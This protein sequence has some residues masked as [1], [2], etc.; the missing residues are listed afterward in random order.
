MGPSSI[1]SYLTKASFS[2]YGYTSQ[3]RRIRPFIFRIGLCFSL[4]MGTLLMGAGWRM[5][6]SLFPAKE[7]RKTQLTLGNVYTEMA[8][9]S[10]AWTIRQFFL[11]P[12]AKADP[13]VPYTILR[14]NTDGEV[15]DEVE[16]N[17]LPPAVCQVPS[18]S[19]SSTGIRLNRLED[20][21]GK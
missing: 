15:T 5:A 3:E 9:L 17:E 13:Q 10:P 20:R 21:S 12:S 11:S 2:K 4:S 16:S 18:P 7:I 14:W 6:F 1:I 8:R 19:S